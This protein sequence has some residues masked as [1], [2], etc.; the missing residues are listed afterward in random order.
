[1][2]EMTPGPLT[3][4]LIALCHDPDLLE[5]FQSEEFSIAGTGLTQEQ[6]ELL[7][8]GQLAEIQVAVRDEYPADSPIYA[9][10]WIQIRWIF[11]TSGDEPSEK[12]SDEPS[13]EPES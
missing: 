9:A 3:S 4:F 5:Q 13:H 7:R 6:L 8:R 11:G 10:I 12:P 1:M 2:A